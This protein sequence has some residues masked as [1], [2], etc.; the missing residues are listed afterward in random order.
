MNNPRKYA[1]STLVI[2]ALSSCWQPA[3]AQSNPNENFNQLADEYFDTYLLPANPSQAVSL[4]VHQYDAKLEDYSK[5]G[6]QHEIELLQKFA[7]RVEAVNPVTLDEQTRADRELVVNNIHSRLLTLQKIKPWEKDPNYYSGGITSAAFVIMERK[8][9]PENDRL[10]SLIA[11]EKLMPA[12]LADARKNLKNPPKVYTEI[13]IEQMPGLIA[14]FKNDVPQA[15]TKVTDSALKQEFNQ[16]NAEVIAA[17]ES[18]QTWMEKDLLPKSQG[19]FRIGADNFSKKL[20]YDEMVDLPLARLLEIGKADLKKNQLAYQQL[21]KTLSKG[22]S[23]QAVEAAN[24]ANHP[25]ADKVLTTYGKTFDDLIAFIRKNKIITIPSDVRPIMEETPP[26]LRAITLASMDTPGPFEKTAKEAYFNVT[27]PD[28]RWDKAKIKDFM[29]NFNYQVIS[30]IS[31]HE[32]YPGHYVQFLWMHNVPG[33]VRKILGSNSNAEGWAHYCEQMMLDEGYGQ[34]G[35]A[36]Q[37]ELLRLG[38]IKAALLRDARFIVGIEM[39][40]GKMTM[41]QA[42]EFFIKQG[43]QPASTAEIEVKRGT[44]D[45]TYLIYTLGKL[46]IMKLR[47]DMQAKQGK[48]FNLQKFHDDFMRQGFPPIKIVRRAMMQDDS[49]TL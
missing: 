32:T 39:H 8:F 44:S 37:A 21:L 18:Y 23:Q 35:N 1:L 49:A 2:L 40:T 24:D 3:F 6:V 33:R 38:Q 14:F 22:K 20:Q 46:Q 48:D 28:A 10:R 7:K 45:P 34:S 47:N 5:A 42:R 13:A 27:L 25:A 26:F 31:I 29:S 36:R 30:S 43:F 41:E 15:F 17:L 11:R 4:G 9:A 19:D 16:S 12:A